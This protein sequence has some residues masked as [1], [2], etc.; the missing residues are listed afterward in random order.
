MAK[1]LQN[2]SNTEARTF[3]K[4]LND[5]VNDFHLPK[6]S[7][8]HG[9]NAINNSK[10]G[11]L[12]KLGNEPGN[13]ECITVEHTIIGF[14]HLEAD[15]WV[16]Y[17]T[18]D[19]NHHEIGLFKEDGCKYQRVVVDEC[20]AFSKYNLII[21]TSRATGDCVYEVYWADGKNS[22]RTISL[23][24]EDFTN[25]LYTNP[26]SP[27][28]WIT[29]SSTVNNCTTYT[30]TN[31]LD[32][33]KIMVAKLV[34]QPEIK[35]QNGISGGTLANG[36]YMVFIAYSINGQKVSD[37][38]P[39][40]V[41]ALF[42]HDNTA[43][44]LD[45][46]IESID[47]DYDEFI[48]V[49]LYVVDQ[50]TV[51][52][53]VGTYSTRQKLLAFDIISPTWPAYPIEQL[54]LITPIVDKS[55]A[56]YNVGDYL[57]RVGPTSKL[58]FNY[59][60]LANQIVT[61]WVSVEYPTDYYRKGGN[62]AGYLRDE[63]YPFFIRYI[64][65]TGDK[66]ASYHIPGRPAMVIGNPS[67]PY[68]SNDLGA[69]GPE[70]ISGDTFFF[71]TQNTAITTATSQSIQLP[72]GGV[73]IAEGYMGYWE[74]I[75]Q[76][77]DD[78]AEVW[79]ANN[80]NHPWTAPNNPIYPGSNI[81]PNGD[82]DICGN[83]IR[84]HKFPEEALHPDVELL[85]PN[86]KNAIRILGVK[87]ENVRPPVDN[88]GIPIAGIVGYEILRGSR[89]GNKTIIAKGIINNM[90]GV[91]SIE[92][93][94]STLGLYPNY[95]YNDLTADPF[96][97]TTPT[98]QKFSFFGAALGNDGATLQ[99]SYSDI[100]HTFHSPDTNFTRPYLNAKEMKVYGNIYGN[101]EGNFRISE[102]HPKEKLL[103]N[104]SFF[105][106]AVAGIGI[107]S[108]AMNG[109][110]TTNYIPP[111]TP[112][113]SDSEWVPIVDTYAITDTN[114]P[115]SIPNAIAGAVIKTSA[116]IITS[117][118]V[119]D[120]IA[121]PAINTL[122]QTQ[123]SLFNNSWASASLT[124]GLAGASPASLYTVL[125]GTVTGLAAG[126][127]AFATSRTEFSQEDSSYGLVP[128]P[129]R[130]AQN[131][132]MF[133][134]YF[135]QGT[136]NTLELIRAL[137]PFRDYMLRYD[138]HAFYNNY[139]KP[140]TSPAQRR[141]L[142]NDQQYIGPQLVDLKAGF[143]VNNLNRAST[144]SIE[145][146]QKSGVGILPPGV[147]DRSRYK[148]GDVNDSNF[149]KKPTSYTITGTTGYNGSVPTNNQGNH[150]VASSHYVGLKQRLRNQYGQLNNIVEINIPSTIVAKTV[151]FTPVMFGGDTYIG[152][153]TEK[154]TFFYFYDWLYGQPDG[155]QFD[156][157][158]H[159]TLLYPRY[160]ANFE[161]FDTS[162]F[163]S[164]FLG[165]L[166]TPSNWI[167]PGEFF[168]L[169]GSLFSTLSL[170]VKNAWG[171]LFNSG[172]R[173]FFVESEINLDLRDWGNEITQQHYDPYR[174]TNTQT[175]F[176]TNN[177][178]A[179]NYYKYDYSLSVTKLFSNYVSWGY[180]QEPQYDPTLAETCYQYRPRRMIY[181]LP[182]Q[183]EGRRDN[184]LI[185][186]P[187]N[188]TDTLSRV[189]C[190]KPVNK[191]GA[192]IFFDNMSPVQFLGVDQLQTTSGTKLTIGDGGLFSQPMQNIVN[193]DRPY[194]Y[195][196]CQDRLSVINTPMGIYWISQNQGKIFN[197]TNGIDEI[198]MQ[199]LKWW[200][201]Q[202]LPY[203][204][205]D[206]AIVNIENFELTDNPVSGIGCQSI[207]DNENGLIYFTKKDYVVRRTLAPGITLEYLS[208]DDFMV[209]SNGQ[210]MMQIK[211]GDPAYFEDASWTVSY[212][213]KAKAWI[214]WHDWHPNLLMPG[215]NTFLSILNR[216]INDNGIWVHNE[217]CDLY[218][219]YYGVDYPFEVE[220]MVNTIQDVT[221]LRSIEYIMEAYK[222]APNCYD[223]FYVLDFNFDEAVIYNTE[224]VSGLLKLN[225]SP[226][227]DPTRLIQY[228][229]INVPTSIDI[230]YSKVENK[231]RFNQFW[232]ITDDRGE[233]NPAAQRVIW[234]TEEN[235]YI[236]SLN[237]NNLNYN[238]PLF[239]RKKFRHYTTS[240]LLRRNVSGD[241]KMLVMI[242]DD[243]N[244]HSPR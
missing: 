147:S 194:E 137:V 59:Q 224:Q 237:T 117:P 186:L 93:N 110:R 200:F 81:N 123:M 95:P 114:N 196:S 203:K 177:I 99:S 156:Y 115:P 37:W 232:D 216:G 235:G 116:P 79:D 142:L 17:S 226:K 25:N 169:D 172:V 180:M 60:P 48:C 192:L 63:V 2:T 40:N 8:T 159:R 193:A 152:R 126:S 53:Q 218:C 96:L 36:S 16:V 42:N 163:T 145:L 100:F 66:T 241:R 174:F 39:S 38:Y 189:T 136:D 86:N 144:V 164:T 105:I 227:N 1:G 185:Y 205:T 150:Q 45:V 222:Y 148:V 231:Y 134:N 19:L 230:L 155:A 50:Q 162:D 78:K 64:W 153:Y 187:N 67:Y 139:M 87:F 52:R 170:S 112:G 212:D 47:T 167:T 109:K 135:T 103:T 133:F 131:V 27:V 221:T 46:V 94:T 55:D 202:Y 35:V 54:P 6:N 83:K 204:L 33:E 238:K 158:I 108:L 111:G 61:K 91:Y 9:R 97:S 74:S 240:V 104:L 160:W 101:V 77:P 49:V 199:D 201:A 18:D 225:L 220:Y 128:L 89:T 98:S 73:Q 239:Q 23:D 20:L 12:G 228:P 129:I 165:N 184:W 166:L 219:N 132:P 10:T 175:L 214:G 161:Q 3:D 90:G 70:A 11:D 26:N 82:Y 138:S 22:D 206:Q 215:K 178:K 24:A 5:D 181:S 149:R 57:I 151:S 119:T 72:D 69:P 7:W 122:I 34:S 125:N 92:G 190:I 198:S 76:Y 32:C 13:K 211:L 44:S 15:K 143:R 209:L 197:M 31:K 171:Y 157:N 140:T 85:N 88:D 62:N 168:N 233:Y 141:W 217:R 242:T 56:M 68:L 127:N 107:S 182:A 113:F 244:L 210:N 65:N 208:A 43:S 195:A 58:N 41:Q 106:S 14:I 207:Y 236:R 179:D 121:I 176:D 84:H 146:T 188:Y 102:E 71:E 118:H 154:N 4:E 80:P 173:D 191:N 28:K 183:F 124:S 29:T 213:P 229:I 120:L 223:R 234:N 51:A 75:E 30:N 21:G 130:I 243:K